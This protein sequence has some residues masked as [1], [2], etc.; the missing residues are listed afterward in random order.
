MKNKYVRTIVGI[1]GIVKESEI[2][3]RLNTADDIWAEVIRKSVIYGEKQGA[4]KELKELIPFS[5][6][7]TTLGGD[8]NYPELLEYLEKRIKKLEE[9]SKDNRVYVE[10]D[11]LKW[12]TTK[13]IA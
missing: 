3:N 4:L 12:L 6:K 10:R 11:D 8:T 5:E 9:I 1:L 7:I 2:Y 13:R